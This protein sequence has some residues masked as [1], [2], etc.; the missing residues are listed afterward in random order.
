MS[1]II[2]NGNEVVFHESKQF[3]QKCLS[4]NALDADYWN[5]PAES[6]ITELWNE[7]P[8]KSWATNDENNNVTVEAPLAELQL[9]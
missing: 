8:E 9:S 6:S 1:K 4:E 2:L 7:E 3:E 5:E